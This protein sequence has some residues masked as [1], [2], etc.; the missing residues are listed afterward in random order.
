MKIFTIASVFFLF[1]VTSC[2]SKSKPP[3]TAPVLLKDDSMSV[4]NE[5]GLVWFPLTWSFKLAQFSKGGPKLDRLEL[6][7]VGLVVSR[8]N[9]TEQF[10]KLKR[11]GG[12]A[13]GNSF[14]LN[15]HDASVTLVSDP[16][17]SLPAG[18]YTIVG[19]R[20]TYVDA[21]SQK[22]RAIDLPLSN[23]FQAPARTPIQFVVRDHKIS[24]LARIAAQSNFG[25]KDDALQ[26]LTD[27]EPIDREVVPVDV[28][29]RAVRRPQSDAKLVFAAIPDLPRS[30]QELKTGDDEQTATGEKAYARVGLLIDVPC[31]IE[32]TLKLIWKRSGDDREYYSLFPLSAVVG[33][34][35]QGKRV[36]T[37]V[38]SLPRGDWILKANYI[39]KNQTFVPSFKLSAL[40]SV[41]NELNSY[42][43]L[44]DAQVPLLNINLEREIE[45]QFMARLSELSIPKYNN[46]SLFYMGR[47]EL[48]PKTASDEKT[49]LWETL[50]RR[51]YEIKTLKMRFQ[52]EDIYNAYTLDPMLRDRTQGNRIH[53]LLRVSTNAVDSKKQ[54]PFNAEFRKDTTEHFA[55]CIKE[56]EEV[57][58]LV[59]ISGRIVFTA[60]KGSNS[61][62]LKE[63]IIEGRAGSSEQWIDECLKKHVVAF[64]FSKAIP[65]S[66]QGELKFASE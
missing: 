29:L 47:F 63:L 48:V 28:V 44:D 21:S 24:A 14:V 30:R 1:F 59:N 13:G 39:F 17:V 46:Q 42:Y 56:R 64:R 15:G 49:L 65:G 32:G 52:A 62:N 41:P 43:M 22:S 19:V 54:E 8:S 27:I 40:K 12:D 16:V 18:E 20:A 6:R 37:P 3:S 11:L 60:L 10:F 36:I 23:P 26:V 50:F 61:V 9:K 4:P 55:Q 2:V 5:G 33:P 57:D 51:G 34:E 35:C 25:L 45:R 66:I 7:N 58:P 53:S 31:Q 38:L